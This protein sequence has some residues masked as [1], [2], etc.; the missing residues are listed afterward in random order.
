MLFL[1][2]PLHA[3]ARPAG[4]IKAPSA[5]GEIHGKLA[6]NGSGAP[7]NSGSVSVTRASAKPGGAAGSFVSGALPQAD[8]SFRVDGLP[9]GRYTVRVRSLGFAPVVRDDVTIT[10]AQPSVDL[11]TIVLSRVAVRIGEQVVTAEREDVQLQ[12]DRNVYS[13]KNM[14][15]ASGGSAI[16]VLRNVPSVEV[17][18]SNNVTL[19][20]NQ[21]VVVQINGRSSPLKGDQLGNF[22]AQL[23]ASVIKN[24]EV[25]TNPSAKN[26][27]EGTAG[28][29]N[30]VL[31]QE[32][33]I[34]L[35]GGLNF[36]GGTNGQVN[37]SGNVGRQ[38][39]PFTWFV[40][41]GLFGGHQ[42]MSGWSEQTNLI[43]P[44]PAT[45]NSRIAGSNGPLWQN[46]T[47][48]TEYRFTPHDALSAD[49]M[50]SGGHFSRN[51]ASYFSDL[52]E[53]GDVI[54]LFD[55]FNNG[56]SSNAMQDYD[57]AYRRTSNAALDRTFSTELDLT[58]NSNQGL[59]NIFGD[60]RQGDETTGAV[61]IPTERD[62]T[63]GAFPRVSFQGD[64]TQPWST[65]TKLETG[66][67][68]L[69]RHTTSN[70]DASYLDSTTDA[71]VPAPSR[72]TSFDYREQIG[73]GYA[74]LSQRIGKVQAQGGL[75]LEEAVTQLGLPTAPADSQR[76]DN[77]YASAYPSGILSYNFTP[78]RQVKLSYS[79]RVT[80]PDP[81]QLSPVE[82]FQDS[83]DIFRGN[84]GLR[85]E[86]T[87][88][89]E[90]T[91]QD[92][93]GWG[94]IQI[95]PYLRHTAHAVRYISTTD[96][97]GTTLST[98]DNVASTMQT[99]TDLNVTYHKGRLM[100]FTGGSLYRYSSDASNLPG[101]LSTTATVWSARLNATW[102]ITPTL[103]A[104]AFANY[105]PTYAIEG[106]ETRAFTFLNFALRRKLWGD[107]GSLTLRVSDPF[108]MMTFGS[109]TE[110]PAV[111]SS[112]VRNMGMR[113]IYLA[114]SRNFG[115]QLKLRPKQ[116]EDQPP[117]QPGMP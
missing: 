32:A 110:N 57:F 109:M 43:V 89:V 16:D 51:N 95:N 18:A 38:Q 8:G 80:R 11:G 31:N 49:V 15:N 61:A 62:L 45:V 68:E 76:F 73:A 99:G 14:V 7:V 96:T 85:P 35:S 92:S 41:Y 84:P 60:V 4:P 98:F 25:S 113:G 116:T 17:D 82:Y 91:L 39:G 23:P 114:F 65:G 59:N 64:F 30:I 66:F 53:N 48:R 27:P 90:F 58:R 1:A 100:L 112:T 93:H 67:K 6:E 26:D 79:R 3:Q 81:F 24:V 72:T 69:V 12:P 77:H 37:A 83:R 97:S 36:G 88:A 9:V 87:D 86:Y 50:V 78:A 47:L 94:T 107:K 42:E 22:L 54:A 103:D 13:T 28:I 5:P 21:N 111:I 29:I 102:K 63:S 104:Q 56:T 20:G 52:D 75:R 106:G 55:Q 44:T 71:W 19:R 74:V 115:Q 10:A 46:G 105:R 33:D 2:M 40:S 108:N 34:G 70:F 101:N 117:A